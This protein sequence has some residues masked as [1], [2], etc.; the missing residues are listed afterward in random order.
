MCV[1]RE[2]QIGLFR[3]RLFLA[4]LILYKIDA[5][6][7]QGTFFVLQLSHYTITRIF[8]FTCPDFIPVL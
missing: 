4:I 2:A 1:D 5:W 8:A 3:I 6:D 7:G